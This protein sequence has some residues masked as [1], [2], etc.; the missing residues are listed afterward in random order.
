[1]LLTEGYIWFPWQEA[2]S[3]GV[4]TSPGP[5][6]F[7]APDQGAYEPYSTTDELYPGL[8]LSGL[9]FPGIY[10]VSNVGFYL[11]TM[12]MIDIGQ[13]ID[14]S[15]D[16][17]VT[18]AIVVNK[19]LTPKLSYL[20]IV[21]GMSG[22]PVN[23]TMTALTGDTFATTL[24]ASYY[25]Q[26]FIEVGGLTIPGGTLQ[27]PTSALALRLGFGGDMPGGL[28]YFLFKGLSMY[29]TDIRTAA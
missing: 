27:S 17:F 8:P 9:T 13:D 23:T 1:M 25:S 12:R 20:E 7:A 19:S 18:S 11:P 5:Y 22:T 3:H 21:K 4:G 28:V 24:D 15:A 2:C 26:R 10:T 6:P 16:I 29:F 14:V